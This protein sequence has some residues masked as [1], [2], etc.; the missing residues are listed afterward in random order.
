[1]LRASLPL[2]LLLAA[3]AGED[4]DYPQLLPTEQILA[5]P[6]LS[7]LAT[8]PEAVESELDQ[9]GDGLRGRADAIRG[10]VIEPEFRDQID[11]ASGG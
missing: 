6:V 2:M 3:C 5:E 8:A 7:D 10:P 11:A 9:R 4:Q 1:M